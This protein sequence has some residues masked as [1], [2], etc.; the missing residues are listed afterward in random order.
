M[1]MDSSIRAVKSSTASASVSA[2]ALVSLRMDW[3]GASSDAVPGFA[4]V[5]SVPASP[6]TISACACSFSWSAASVRHLASAAG[7]YFEHR[8]ATIIAKDDPTLYRAAMSESSTVDALGEGGDANRLTYGAGTGG[9]VIG[10]VTPPG[11]EEGGVVVDG[12]AAGCSAASLKN[13]NVASLRSAEVAFSS[14]L[15]RRRG[16]GGLMPP[17]FA[18]RAAAAFS[19]SAAAFSLSAAEGCGAGRQDDGRQ[20]F[21]STPPGAACAAGRT[22][23][24]QLLGAAG[25]FA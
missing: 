17:G 25:P 15:V 12:A 1:L 10:R 11:F 2:V 19:L 24:T 7:T 14:A 4:A 8:T 18:A 22:A 5:C 13:R 9:G 3:N 21:H 16:C 6:A 20:A 23:G